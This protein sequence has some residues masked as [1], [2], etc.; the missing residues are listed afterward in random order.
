MKKSFWLILAIAAILGLCFLE[1]ILG[2]ADISG[3]EI[4]DALLGNEQNAEKQ[5]ITTIVFESRIP[6]IL[7]AITAGAGLSVCGL[8][9]QTYFR[10]PLAGPGVLGISSGASLGVALVILGGGTLGAFS[11]FKNFAIPLA[12]ILGSAIVL[13][14]IL[15]AARKLK[16]QL[17]LL[18]IGL[19]LGYLTAGIVSVLQFGATEESIKAMVFWGLGSFQAATWSQ[20]TIMMCLVIPALLVSIL[21]SK[22]LNAMLL[23]EEE[24]ATVGLNFKQMSIVILVLS[25][26][27]TGIVTATCGPI[28]FIGLSVPHLVRSW[29]KSSDHK[30]LLP[31]SLLFGMIIAL[32]CDLMSRMPWTEQ[33]LPLNAVT[34]LIGAPVVLSIVL[35]SRGLK[36]FY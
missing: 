25:G 27:M 14:V 7:T 33:S 19:M 31:A 29:F 23:G 26:V 12:A 22:S 2:S 3:R 4:W 18:I 20:L 16:D 5:Y 30:L 17:S 36:S 1:L 13:L 32:F 8:M 15:F 6:R 24:S 35:R 9:L 28:A 21:L 11:S 10:N 34:S